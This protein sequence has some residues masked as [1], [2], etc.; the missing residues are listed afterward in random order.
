MGTSAFAIISGLILYSILDVINY[1]EEI[2]DNASLNAAL[3][4]EYCRAP[5]LFGYQDEAEDALKKLDAIP[6]VVNACVYDKNNKPFAYYNKKPTNNFSFPVLS[7]QNTIS[8]QNYLHVFKPL[9]FNNEKYGTIYLRVSIV[10]INEKITNT[11]FIIVLLLLGLGFPIYFLASKLQ[12]LISSPITEL[13]DITNRITEAEDY[14][15][16]VE[17]DNKDETG[18]LYD[19]FNDMLVQ[20][21]KRQKEIDKASN[22]LRKTNEQLMNE[23]IEREK[24][25]KALKESE[26]HYRYLF[27]KNP[28]P[29]LVYELNT[30]NMLAVNDAFIEHYGFSK[31]EALMLHLPDLYPESEKKA[32]A[33]LST[34]L[35]G[36]AY[37][38]EWHHQKK[39]GTIINIEAH[40]HSISLEGKAARIAVITDITERIQAGEKLRQSEEQFRLISEN[41]ADMIVVLSLDGK[42][43]YSN[44]S[45]EPILG[46][47]HSLPGTDSFQEIHPDDREMIKNIFNE[48]I[49]TGK[50]HRAEYRLIDKKGNIHFIES[51]GSVI[52]N[53]KGD[54]INVVV[55]SRDITPRKKTEEELL[56]RQK[57][58]DQAS[59]ELK[60]LN[61]ELEDRV[62][63][64]T[65]EL[66]KEIE[67]RKITE[68]ALLDSE[69]RLE[70]ILNYAP[71]L[72]YINNLEGRY[73]FVNEEFERLMELPSAEVLNK[74]DLELFTKE[75]AERNITQ[76]KKVISTKRS[77]IFEN[78]SQKK[79]GMHYFVDILFPIID[80]NNE[81]YA[82]CGWSIDIT[83]RKKSELV[84]HEAK[85]RAESADRLKSAFL[86][87]MSHEL[88]TPL[89]SII[90][91]TGILMK[92]IAGPLN[93]E[94]LKQLGMAKGSAQHLL[95]LINDVLDISKI[96]AGQLVV[97][98]NKFDFSKAI[99]KVAS[100]VQP[101]AEKKDIK[102]QIEISKNVNGINSDERR[103]EQILLNLFNNAIKFTDSG[104]VKVQCEIVDKNIV[105]KV[106][107]TGI[108]I[109]KDDMDKLFKPFS[110]VDSGLTRNH[111]G[112]G[113]GLSISQKLVEKLGGIITVE[114]EVGVGSTFTVTLPL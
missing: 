104:S 21:N 24:V 98:L 50:G 63:H 47:V 23:L 76:N 20:L 69:Q 9:I 75:R 44:P 64:R 33:D 27:E 70:N 42:R 14:S 56:K 13:A 17:T 2:K 55:V 57:E 37:V 18:I 111:E 89:N 51:Q 15:I 87:T 106:I 80:S 72:V 107:D 1:K 78:A 88:R 39:N 79:D 103:V 97:S 74:T 30:L 58:I 66:V 62:N 16:K 99:Q 48:T 25:E 22:D 8:H 35:Q 34:K 49:K 29:M 95:A 68:K 38:G 110:Q 31:N 53:E 113:L 100:I 73:I 10:S 67:I 84:L 82:T 60:K 77:Q 101:L 112:T 114:S 3:V 108:G 36:H 11:V 6:D 28:M 40:S 94:Q 81:I 93:D 12:R 102:L 61:E 7:N 41:V 91:F 96:E 83:D 59:Q 105:T 19:R 43:V 46:N 54:M 71:I 4:G 109:R 32:I 90:G 5:L 45:Y 52:R 92:G 26:I 85:E 65:Q 86:A